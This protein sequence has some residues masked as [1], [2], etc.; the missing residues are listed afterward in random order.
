MRDLA[1]D[2]LVPTLLA[3]AYTAAC[4]LPLAEALPASLAWTRRCWDA[5]DD[6][7]PL[8]LVHDLGHLLVLGRDFRFASARDLARWPEPERAARLA[9]EDRVLGRWSLDPTL[10]DAHVLVAG[11]DPAARDL[12]VAHA[13]RLALAR[14]LDG[15]TACVRAN[16]AHLRA[17]AP[18]ALNALPARFEDWPA[19]PDDEHR[20]WALAQREQLR[21]SLPTDRLFAPEDLWELAHLKDLPSESARLALRDVLGLAARVGPVAPAVAA[22]LRQRVREVPVEA[23]EAA[24]YPAGGF[25]EVSTRG[26]FENLVRSEMVYVGEGTDGAFDLFDVRFA[27][28]ELL[29]YTR[30]ESPLLDARRELTVVFDRPASLRVKHRGAPAQS[31]VMASAL[32]LALQADLVRV[33]GPTGA[34]VQ[35]VWRCDHPDDRAAA[36]EERALLALPLAAEV[37][38][39]RV[40]LRVVDGVVEGARG[41]RVICASQP[42][43]ADLRDAV[44]VHCAGEAWEALG[45]R[46]PMGDGPSGLR[47]LA[48][49]ILQVTAQRATVRR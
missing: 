37:A 18:A 42:A 10:L 27:E 3:W 35:L 44:W 25:D 49:A 32:A 9:W 5:G 16:P 26:S 14:A 36:D 12:A 47:A 17:L 31:L 8:S 20:A 15:H 30:D 40:S 28:S 34:R 41:A 45:E 48:D 13:V 2:D 22:S 6:H 1:R 43:P 39:Q 23:E 21:A 7:L 38:H 33:C 46:W 24:E 19:I 11:L 29:F 4:A